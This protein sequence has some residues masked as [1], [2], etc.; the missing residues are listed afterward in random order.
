MK[1]RSKYIDQIKVSPNE[2]PV[3]IDNDGDDD[4]DFIIQRKQVVIDD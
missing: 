4:D 1:V 2:R 3:A